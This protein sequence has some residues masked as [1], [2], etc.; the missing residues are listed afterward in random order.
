[1]NKFNH[2]SAIGRKLLEIILVIAL[3]FLLA[4]VVKWRLDHMYQSSL[5]GKK[6]K[7][8]MVD[9]AKKIH[10]ELTGKHTAAPSPSTDQ[11]QAE[12]TS[13]I[14][15]TIAQGCDWQSTGKILQQEGLITDWNTYH[16]LVDQMG[17][18]HRFQPGTYDVE[19]GTKV[20]DLLAKLCGTEVKTYD[21]TIAE[22]ANGDDVGKMLQKMGV[23]SSAQD[24]G[25]ETKKMGVYY[26]FKP[27]THHIE[28]PQKMTYLIHKLT[29]IK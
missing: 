5:A 20:K 24:F 16:V 14:T 2:L 6:V 17:I 26:G 29:G 15:L 27:G 12:H 1:M 22:G 8:T 25:E 28:M 18:A 19:K 4:F 23:I 3:I 13:K 10:N 7:F 11:P 21:I 9:A